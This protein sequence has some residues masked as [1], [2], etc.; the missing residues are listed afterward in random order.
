MVLVRE[1]MER[2]EEDDSLFM[3]TLDWIIWLIVGF[4]SSIVA[5][6]ICLWVVFLL[7]DI[8]NGNYEMGQAH[9][10]EVILS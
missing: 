10:S 3:K 7:V 2:I 4:F 1:W 8:W 6:I 5:I 9:Q